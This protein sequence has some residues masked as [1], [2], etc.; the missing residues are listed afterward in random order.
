V[1]IAAAV[2]FQVAA[3]YWPPFADRGVGWHGRLALLIVYA[4][5]IQ[6]L[7]LVVAAT[8]AAMATRWSH[9]IHG[10]ALATS[11]NVVVAGGLFV[12]AVIG[13]IAYGT[14]SH[15]GFVL[16]GHNAVYWAEGI[17]TAVISAVATALALTGHAARL[18]DL[19]SSTTL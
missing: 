12:T 11:V 10:R 19:D 7:E 8:L 1:G 17:G 14:L 15:D 16:A 6:A 9:V 2:A 4:T 13:L 18:T 5:P 3:A